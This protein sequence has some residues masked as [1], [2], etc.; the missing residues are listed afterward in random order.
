MNVYN[1]AI[2]PHKDICKM[3]PHFGAQSKFLLP[4][5]AK[6]GNNAVMPCAFRF[7]LSKLVISIRLDRH[8]D[9]RDVPPKSACASLEFL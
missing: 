4:Q 6:Q 2:E 3:V 8:T 7:K 9:C 1:N 5:I